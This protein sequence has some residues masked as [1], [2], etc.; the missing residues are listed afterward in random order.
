M[1]LRDR[2]MA[3]EDG[4]VVETGSPM[5]PAYSIGDKGICPPLLKLLNCKSNDS[6]VNSYRCGSE[7]G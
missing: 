7:R 5:C 3:D 4:H 6:F 2:S 1:L